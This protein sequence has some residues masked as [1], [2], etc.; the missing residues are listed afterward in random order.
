MAEVTL[1]PPTTNETPNWINLPTPGFLDIKP[2]RHV[3]KKLE[4]KEFVEP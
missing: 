2:A 3:L 1:E 4:K